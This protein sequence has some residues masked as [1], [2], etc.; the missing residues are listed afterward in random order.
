MSFKLKSSFYQSSNDPSEGDD[1]NGDAVATPENISMRRVRV[2]LY[3]E[4]IVYSQNNTF[5]KMSNVHNCNNMDSYIDYVKRSNY[6]RS[7]E[8]EMIYNEALSLYNNRNMYIRKKYK[9]EFYVNLKRNLRRARFFGDDND[10]LQRGEEGREDDERGMPEPMDYTEERNLNEFIYRERK[11]KKAILFRKKYMEIFSEGGSTANIANVA[12]AADTANAANTANDANTPNAA[13]T[14]NA[15]NTANTADTANDANGPRDTQQRTQMML[16]GLTHNSSETG[17][18]VKKND[19]LLSQNGEDVGLPL[20]SPADMPC[21]GNRPKAN[22]LSDLRD[23]NSMSDS[24]GMSQEEETNFLEQLI[25]L[26]YT[27]EY[28]SQLSDLFEN[29]RTL[30]KANV[31]VL[32]W[33]DYQLSNGYWLERLSLFLLGLTIAIGVGN[34]ETF[35]SLMSTWHGVI[36][37]VPYII[38]YCLVCHPILTFEL[39]IGQL[40][41]MSSPFIFYRLLKQCASVGFLM[42]LTCLINGYINTYRTAAEYFIYLINSFKRDLPWKLNKKE[43]DFCTSFKNDF[44]ECHKFRPLCFFSRSISSCVPN[45]LGKAFLIYHN[46]FF[47]P[48]F[49]Y[50]R[51][52][53]IDGSENLAHIFSTGTSYIDKDTFIFLFV[54]NFFVTIFQL[55]GLTNFA[56]SSALVLLLIGFLSITQFASMFNLTSATQAYFHVLKSWK[57]SYLYTYSSIWSQCVSFALY[58]LSIGMGIYSSLATKTRIGANLAF[59]GYAIT[60]WNSIISSLMFFSA[61]SVIGFIADSINSNFVDMLEFSRKDCSFILFPVGFTHL[62]RMEKTLS[63]LYYGSYTILSCA[64]LAIQCEVL[65]M[66]IRNFKFCKNVKKRTIILTLSFFFFLSSFLISNKDTKNILWFVSLTISENA[67]VF[68]SL[69]ICIILGW[70][71]NIDFQFRN[72][73]KRSVLSFNSTYWILNLSISVLFNYLPYHVYVL[74]I[75]RL[76]IFSVSTLVAMYVLKKEIKTKQGYKKKHLSNLTYK[77][78]LYILYIGNIEELRMEL[79]RIISGNVFMGNISMGWSI[80]I[81]Y[82]GTSILLSAFI[83]FADGMFYSKELKEKMQLI[84]QGWVVFAILF[85]VFTLLLLVLFPLCITVFEKWC[86]QEDCFADFALLPSKPL[87]EIHNFSILSYF[88]EFTGEGRK[89][90]RRRAE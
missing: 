2:E 23:L 24:S 14:E 82:I 29:P 80:C 4:A 35:W 54:C 52:L 47:P 48:N 62:Q 87:R 63:M 27:P 5:Y 45:S 73:T 18:V 78:T 55:L 31:K 68:V 77:E 40:I 3:D 50:D 65:V 1:K 74:Y 42:V 22:I 86:A 58:E 85:W 61:V 16:A 21:E 36:F 28:V 60:T 72:L 8:Q 53:H 7:Y 51:L 56:F 57:F 37:V 59:D 25:K 70:L 49:F 32:K 67:R 13:N 81:K 71:Y 66:T 15:S 39:Y 76:G 34:I 9:N 38:C 43:I 89:K 83:E 10:D 26:R 20:P 84:P 69:L 88:C 30:K 17:G 41:R 64:S 44:I 11:K 19:S 6:T 33:L 90:G 75:I 46:K 12:N 79:Q